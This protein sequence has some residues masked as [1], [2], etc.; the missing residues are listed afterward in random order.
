MPYCVICNNDGIINA[1][2]VTTPDENSGQARRPSSRLCYRQ[3]TIWVIYPRTYKAIV[4]NNPESSLRFFCH[5]T[6]RNF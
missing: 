3:R 6:R 4:R 1:M 5:R 2:L